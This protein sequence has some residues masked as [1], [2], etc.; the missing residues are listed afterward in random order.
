M[1]NSQTAAVQYKTSILS[2]IAL[3]TL[4]V[5]CGGGGGG[6]GGGA[7]A[8]AP[9]SPQNQPAQFRVMRLSLDE[10]V[11]ES[12]NTGATVNS[13][14]L[15][16]ELTA[17]GAV[18]SSET[19][20]VAMLTLANRTDPVRVRLEFDEP[21]FAIATFEVEIDPTDLSQLALDVSI[22]QKNQFI[23]ANGAAIPLPSGTM[24]RLSAM[25]TSPQNVLGLTPVDSPTLRWETSTAMVTSESD[26]LFT[27]TNA[28][29]V[30][31]TFTVNL[32]ATSSVVRQA[33]GIAF[34]EGNTSATFL[35]S[36]AGGAGGNTGGGNNGGGGNTGGG[37]MVNPDF[38]IALISSST[39]TGQDVSISIDPGG[40]TPPGT[41]EALLVVVESS[42]GSTA[43]T[44]LFTSSPAVFNRLPRGISKITVTRGSI[45][46]LNQRE[47]VEGGMITAD[48]QNNVEVN[49]GSTP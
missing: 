40:T 21:G 9:S 10:Y 37:G 19:A 3:V 1:N 24:L 25:I 27:L 31:S 48:I 39:I 36:P 30:V 42:T 32:T 7:G 23:D 15:Y 11:L 34:I 41:N 38:G 33:D 8:S 18:I 26:P 16:E 29:S 20:P 47:L 13:S 2:L 4:L 44:F 12:L 35:V 22:D 43:S 46:L 49:N 14:Y 45:V 28:T 5:G 17:T 6:G